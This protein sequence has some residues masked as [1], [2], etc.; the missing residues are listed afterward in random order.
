MNYE[1]YRLK[2]CLSALV[3]MFFTLLYSSLSHK[4]GWDLVEIEKTQYSEANIRVK[5][6][7]TMR[8]SPRD[9]AQALTRSHGE[10]DLSGNGFLCSAT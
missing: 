10:W 3:I 7:T 9:I 1:K 4:L 2:C 6:K 5:C 8:V